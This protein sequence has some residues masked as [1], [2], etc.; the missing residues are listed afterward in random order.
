[1]KLTAEELQA[2]RERAE[3]ATEGKWIFERT[4]GLFT[5]YMGDRNEASFTYYDGDEVMADGEF[6]AESRTDVPKLLELVAQQAAEVERL[7]AE[8][9]ERDERAYQDY[10]DSRNREG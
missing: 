6:I 8:I 7:Q 3:V 9:D 4:N 10:L 1:M 5:L 2:I